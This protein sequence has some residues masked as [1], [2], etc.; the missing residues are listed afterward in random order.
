MSGTLIFGS[1]AWL[2]VAVVLLLLGI[3]LVAWRY[4]N[5]PLEGVAGWLVLQL[6]LQAWPCLLGPFSR[7]PSWLALL[8]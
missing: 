5:A 6:W 8:P 2:A 4:W 3:A 7:E 1:Q